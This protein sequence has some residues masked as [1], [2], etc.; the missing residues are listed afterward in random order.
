M[1]EPIVS[2]EE[3]K[4]QRL[5]YQARLARLQEEYDRLLLE[6]DKAERG[7]ERVKGGIAALSALLLPVEK[8]PDEEAGEP[9]EPASS[10]AGSSCTAWANPRWPSTPTVNVTATLRLSEAQKTAL[11]SDFEQRI[12]HSLRQAGLG[13]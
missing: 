4:A 12:V 6:L 5:E 8:V 11:F 9:A 13:L 10:M 7:M 1:A 2:R 3:I